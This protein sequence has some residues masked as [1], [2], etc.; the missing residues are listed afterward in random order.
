MKTCRVVKQA[1]AV[2]MVRVD[3]TVAD[4]ERA[5]KEVGVDLAPDEARRIKSLIGRDPS[6]TELYIFDIMWSE[7]C[8]YKSSKPILQAYLPTEGSRVIIGPGED[9]GVV[10]L[11]EADGRS[12]V[13]AVAHESHNHPS[14]IL[15]VE[16]AAT[17][18]GGIVRDVYCMGADVVGVM[19]ALRF[20]DPDGPKAE[21]VREVAA[22]V[23]RGI[24]EY[25]NALGVPN[26]GGDVFFDRG[27]DENCLVNVV[28]VGIAEEKE[29]I[30]S[31]VPQAAS[32]EAYDLILIGKPTDM[33][34]LGGATMASRILDETEEGNLGAV[35]LHDPFLKRMLTEATRAVIA[36]LRGSGVDMGFKD[37]GAGGISCAVSEMVGAGG[38]GAQLDLDRVHVAFDSIESYAI[39]CSET[40]ERYCLAVP[41]H[42]SER[43]LK[44]YNDDF[45]LPHIYRGARA[46]VIGRVTEKRDLVMTRAGKVVAHLPVEIVNQGISYDRKSEPR[47]AAPGGEERPDTGDIKSACLSV[48]SLLS[49]S[50]KHYVYRH[51]DSEV[52]GM[53]VLKPGEAD[54]GVI[55]V[56][57]TCLGV[58]MAVDGNPRYSRIDPYTGGALAVCESMRNVASVGAVPVALT[59]C[60]NFGNPE[61][62][63]VFHDFVETVR[64]IGDAARALWGYGTREPVPIVSGNVSFYNESSSGAAIPP[65]PVVAC[66]GVLD[67]YSVAVSV[68]L[69]Q[70]ASDLILIGARKP[71][72]GGS[73]LMAAAGL[74]GRGRLPALDLQGERSAIHAVTEIIRS[75]HALAC[76]DISEGG[77]FGALAEMVIGG[78]GM[79]EFGAEIDLTSDPGLTH[80]DVIFSECGGFVVET[81]SSSRSD[82]MEIS[83]RFAV[84]SKIIGK[85]VSDN[86]LVI[87]IGGETVV[88]LGA[89]E[90]RDAWLSPVER[91]I[92]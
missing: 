60:L 36:D 22:G 20:G 64:G 57:G 41:S 27:Y 1:G 15:P 78:W 13:L 9:A 31:R 18:I 85:T 91:A 44:I 49:V 29:I 10:R 74:D 68:C 79:G 70:A 34:G 11:G 80:D 63:H 43:V 26:V 67:D 65:S 66:Y 5:L 83:S 48:L 21:S 32:R 24:W 81:S 33:S 12:Y 56:P 54:A 47:A 17:G 61:D 92:G 19:D 51:Y 58:A 72:L 77:L 90:M 4:I 53:S 73:A 46:S 16:G 7:H 89:S 45:E 69:K 8:S 88:S 52:K 35:Q 55:S 62:P 40:Q 28:A 2:Q 6:V 38:F 84:V 39:A 14:Q 82:V 42:A 71:G 86:A 87:K 3:G 23:V 50:S 37:L 59:D 25:G 30:R 76:H 75:G